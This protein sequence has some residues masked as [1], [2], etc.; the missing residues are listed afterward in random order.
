[1]ISKMTCVTFLAALLLGAIAGCASSPAKS[2]TAF[3]TREAA[4]TALADLIGSGD[5][6]RADALLGEGAVEMLSSGDPV[7]DRED[8][9]KVKALIGQ[10]VDFREEGDLTFALVGESAWPFTIPLV[11]DP[12][13]WRFDVEAG[14][15]ELLTRRIGRNELVTI[16]ALHELVDAQREYAAT[17]R[18]G[19]PPCYAAKLWST[20]GRHDGLYWETAAGEPQSPMGPFVADAAEEGYARGEEGPKPFHGY[21][22]RLLTGQG[23]AASGGAK[24]YLGADGL[25]T[26]GFAVV[27]WP[28]TYGNSGIQT[29][30][31][32]HLGIVFERDFGEET[33]AEVAALN[34]YD[35]DREWTP[36][37]VR[38]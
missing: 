32:N 37:V 4:M 24:G 5:V 19:R 35:P 16:A 6:A 22:F 12:V 31:V 28:A 2:G 3:P 15:E 29:F 14:R 7:A 9:L 13:G 17:G 18:D 11:R 34:A 38:E 23:A 36:T 25:L 1:M 27:A 33:A 10:K 21:R 26:G 8:A 20:P 30:L